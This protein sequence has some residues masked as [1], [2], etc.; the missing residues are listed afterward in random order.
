MLLQLEFCYIRN[1]S[2]ERNSCSESV[3]I[4]IFENR[5]SKPIVPASMGDALEGQEGFPQKSRRQNLRHSG[6]R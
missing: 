6:W 2:F 4:G 5:H 3:K 1:I